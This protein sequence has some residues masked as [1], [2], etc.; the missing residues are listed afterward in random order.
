MTTVD[1]RVQ[2]LATDALRH[3]LRGVDVR[4]KFGRPVRTI[5][6]DKITLELTKLAKRLGGK[7]PVAG[8]T[9]SAIVTKV[10]DKS[11]ELEVNLGKWPAGIAVGGAV[12]SRYNPDGLAASERFK[13]GD[14]VRVVVSS[15]PST[16]TASDSDATPALVHSKRA[17]QL[18]PG[19]EG[20]VVVINP[21]TRRVWRRWVDTRQRL[22]VLTELPWPSASLGLHLSRS[23]MLLPWMQATTRPQRS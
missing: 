17:V 23:C 1:R 13:R 12:R 16:D 10:H 15:S 7:E 3:A 8:A 9:Y 21:K 20:A 19:P 22:P 6:S 4:K 5:R 11:G 2:R 14:L 18:A